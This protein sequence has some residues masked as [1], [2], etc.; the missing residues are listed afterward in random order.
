MM[1]I[2]F[3]LHLSD[4]NQLLVAYIECSIE[5]YFYLATN[6]ILFYDLQFFLFC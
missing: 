1:T 5:L 2:W 4:K 6:G 3:M